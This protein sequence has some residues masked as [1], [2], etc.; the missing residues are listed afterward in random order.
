MDALAVVWR[1][2][3]CVA[4]PDRQRTKLKEQEDYFDSAPDRIGKEVQK[5]QESLRGRLGL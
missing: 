4:E 2:D 3:D 5:V 1:D